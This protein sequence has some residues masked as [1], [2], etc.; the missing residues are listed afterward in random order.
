MKKMIFLGAL[1]LI[2]ASACTNSTDDNLPSNDVTNIVSNGNWVVSYFWDKTKDE[3]HKFNGYT[4]V[5]DDNGV[6]RALRQGATTTGTW[7]VNSSQTKFILFLS[8]TDPL[9]EINDDWI[10]VE[11]TANLI[12]LKDDNDE[13]LEELHFRKN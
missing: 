7:S 13:H 5:F 4:F 11:R 9:Q 2:L 6:F 8:N 3:T 12:R 1:A 10:I